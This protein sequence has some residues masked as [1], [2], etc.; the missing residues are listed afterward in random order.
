MIRQSDFNI[1]F[2]HQK[3]LKRNSKRKSEQSR[4]FTTSLFTGRKRNICVFD[5]KRKDLF[6]W[7]QMYRPI[8][9]KRYEQRNQIMEEYKKQKEKEVARHMGESV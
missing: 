3:K 9:Q 5:F 1:K 2:Q 6:L 8:L 4:R 7:R